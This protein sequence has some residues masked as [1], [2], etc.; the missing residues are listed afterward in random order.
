MQL[1]YLTNNTSQHIPSY[2]LEMKTTD[3][4]KAACAEAIAFKHEHVDENATTAARIYHVNSK[5]IQTRLQREHLR[6]NTEVKHGGHNKMLSDVQ[7]E[8]IYQY[9]EDSY[10]SRYSATKAMV[11]AAIKC[12]KANQLPA[13]EPPS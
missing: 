9:V 3:E 8:A 10:L 12:L 11:Y 13:K 6:C 4:Y 7:V 5:T 2:P 1:N